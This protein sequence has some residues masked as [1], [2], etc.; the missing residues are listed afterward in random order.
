VS[1]FH[2]MA[3]CPNETFLATVNGGK[4]DWVLVVGAVALV[5]FAVAALYFWNALRKTRIAGLGGSAGDL[6]LELCEAHELNRLERSLILQLAAT[7][8]IP[9]PATLFVDP[10]SLEQAAAAPGPEANRYAALRQKL[11]GVLE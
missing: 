10:W 5:A 11:F 4:M 2:A 6:F 7:Y 8:E 1:A 3:S 9:Q